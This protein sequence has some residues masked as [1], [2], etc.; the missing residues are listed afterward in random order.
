M[1]EQLHEDDPLNKTLLSLR[2]TSRICHR[3]SERLLFR[4]I[5][6][7]DVTEA[8]TQMSR[9]LLSRLQNPDDALGE[10]VRDMH[11]GPFNDYLNVHH[12]YFESE[13]LRYEAENGTSMSY[14]TW[15]SKLE[16]TF[17]PDGWKDTEEASLDLAPASLNRI[18]QL[19]TNPNSITKDCDFS[20][21][22]MH[23]E[24]Y[25]SPLLE[26]ALRHLTNL[27]SLTWQSRL[28][29][30]RDALQALKQTS[31]LARI[32]VVHTNETLRQNL[33]PLDRILLA[34]SQIHSVDL[35]I[36]S[37]PSSKPHDAYSEYRILQDCLTKG[38]S[39]KRLSISFHCPGFFVEVIPLDTQD[40]ALLHWNHVPRAPLNF[41]WQDGDRFP[42]LREL[43][44]PEEQYHLPES[45]CIAWTRCMD[46]THLLRLDLGR[47]SP[48]HL[49]TTLT[50]RVP[51]LQYLR[52]GTWRRSIIDDTWHSPTPLAMKRFLDSIAALQEV[53]FC[54]TGD[55]RDHLYLFEAHRLSLQI[56][57]LNHETRIGRA[58]RDLALVVL[59][60][61]PRL[62]DATF[63]ITRFG[64]KG[65]WAPAEVGMTPQ[66]KFA[67]LEELNSRL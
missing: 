42:S 53:E 18:Q 41:D 5:I 45:H 29:F 7:S 61:F 2:Q 38:N 21:M 64:L 47:F 56:L 58:G 65:S 57:V 30:P 22:V 8:S 16:R 46:F 43:K 28:P 50:G 11:L 12:D 44:L 14:R 33:M 55:I 35:Y 67:S 26:C 60:M 27:Q 48:Q 49:L 36:Q 19:V 13:V 32:S 62:T 1:H 25:K 4:S 15:L 24:G 66:E 39:I 52:F 37:S 3:E 20:T 10:I 34:T 59:E 54:A 31:P 6:L 63:D 9:M 17:F 23:D 51:Q 40:S